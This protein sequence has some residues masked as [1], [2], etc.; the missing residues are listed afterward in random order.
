MG[1]EPAVRRSGGLAVGVAGGLFAVG[2]LAVLSARP[3]ARP[4]ADIHSEYVKYLSGKDSITA[5]LAYPERRDPAPA[6]IVIHD[7]YG[8]SDRPRPAG[9]KLARGGFVA[10][11]PGLPSREG[12]AGGRRAPAGRGGCPPSCL[13]EGGGG[14]IF[15]PRFSRAGGPLS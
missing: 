5:Y 13:P 14:G 4:T 10:V 15:A 9:G 7:I 6:V 3:A 11:R 2:A 8:V 1:I 12:G